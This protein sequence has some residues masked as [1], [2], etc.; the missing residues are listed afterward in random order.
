MDDKRNGLNGTLIPGNQGYNF[1]MGTMNNNGLGNYTDTLYLNSWADSSAG[2]INAVMFNKSTIGMRIYQG[3]VGETSKF[4]AY[5]DAIMT[6]SN[7]GN[8]TLGAGSNTDGITFGPNTTWSSYLKIG[9]GIERIGTNIA[10]VIA[11][12]IKS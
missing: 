7:S 11:K 12:E 2:N 8:I 4:T 10:Q 1:Y 5:K 3:A 9:E 6:D